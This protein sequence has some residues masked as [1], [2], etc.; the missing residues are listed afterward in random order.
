MVGGEVD[1]SCYAA[2]NAKATLSMC[3]INWKIVEN[4]DRNEHLNRLVFV[5]IL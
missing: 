1:E 4:S 3:G 5:L 2:E